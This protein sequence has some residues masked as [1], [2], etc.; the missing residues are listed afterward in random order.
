MKAFAV[1]VTGLVVIA[2]GARYVLLELREPSS[3]RYTMNDVRLD[4][5][6]RSD[7]RFPE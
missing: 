7:A 1:A 2:I 6:M 3:D 5:D 4:A